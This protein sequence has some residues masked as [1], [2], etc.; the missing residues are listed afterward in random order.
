[1]SLPK[2]ADYPF[3]CKHSR[4]IPQQ[5]VGW[6]PDA[7]LQHVLDYYDESTSALEFMTSFWRHMFF[8]YGGEIV[9][10]LEEQEYLLMKRLKV[11]YEEL[12]RMPRE[13]RLFFLKKELE[14]IEYEERQRREAANQK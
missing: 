13:K 4:T 6:R 8:Q 5:L 2:T 7:L 14:L 3:F 10:S 9:Y 11:G 1:M 12:R